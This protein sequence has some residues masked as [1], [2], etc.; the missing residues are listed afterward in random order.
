MDAVTLERIYDPFFTTKPVGKGT[1]LGLSM[2]HGIVKAHEGCIRVRSHPGR[3][4]TFEI[5]F[6]ALATFVPPAVHRTVE[7]AAGGGERILYVD[8]DELAGRA[9]TRLLER[10]GYRVD[11][12]ALPADALAFFRRAPRD[13]DLVI[14]DLAMPGMPGTELAAEMIR[15]RPDL[16]VLLITGYMDAMQDDAV[17]RTGIRDVLRKPIAPAAL[18]DAV[19]RALASV[20]KAPLARR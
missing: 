8:D 11:H 14:T 17:R 16:P 12:R 4:T 20:E 6:P 13:H 3:G 7:I 5:Y 1:G 18:S 2:V 15:L 10:F 9:I 19:K